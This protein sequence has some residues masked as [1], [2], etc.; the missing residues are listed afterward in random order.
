MHHRL[1]QDKQA[2]S[3]TFIFS[4]N[5]SSKRDSTDKTSSFKFIHLRIETRAKTNMHF[6]LIYRP[7]ETKGFTKKV[8]GTFSARVAKCHRLI[9]GG[10]IAHQPE[11]PMALLLLLLTSSVTLWNCLLPTQK[12]RRSLCAW[13]CPNRRSTLLSQ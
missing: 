6:M 11:V 8:T 5:I 4:A 13:C 12:L 1:S 10:F 3:S 7:P 2:G 9:L